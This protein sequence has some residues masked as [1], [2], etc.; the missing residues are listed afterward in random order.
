MKSLSYTILLYFILSL[1]VVNAQCQ[2]DQLFAG[3]SANCSGT[4]TM[5]AYDNYQN[6]TAYR[7]Y[8]KTSSGSWSYLAETPVEWGSGNYSTNISSTTIFAVSYFNSSNYCESAKV[9]FTV[10]LPAKPNVWGE[11]SSCASGTA[12][13]NA[14]SSTSGVTFYLYKRIGL[15]YTTVA[16]NTTGNFTV[17]NFNSSDAPNYYLKAAK[18]GCWSNG[19]TQVYIEVMGNLSTPTV[20]G[21]TPICKSGSLTLT[22]SGG[23]EGNY[24]WYNSSNQLIN[25]VTGSTYNTGCG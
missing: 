5:S 7:W 3:G 16:N 25:G 15:N 18:T 14:S 8:K 1:D 19:F 4:V 9:E 12:T 10:N 20:S 24:R 6:A 13:I 11:G 2:S 22:A 23:S 21:N 17:N